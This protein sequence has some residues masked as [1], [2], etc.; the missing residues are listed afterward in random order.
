MDPAAGFQLVLNGV[1]P[2]KTNVVEASSDLL[3]WTSIS[4]NVAVSNLLQI[5][6][7]A[8]SNAGPR[9]YR[10]FEIH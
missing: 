5:V 10:S 1:T 6:D 3:N 4:T 2:G 8:V 9:F 7:P